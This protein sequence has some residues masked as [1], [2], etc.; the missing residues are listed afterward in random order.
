VWVNEVL[1]ENQAQ[2]DLELESNLSLTGGF[3]SNEVVRG[4]MVPVA[5]RA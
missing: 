2:F 1:G 3:A 5:G 4:F